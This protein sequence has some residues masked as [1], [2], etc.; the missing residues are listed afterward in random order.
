MVLGVALIVVFVLLA[1]ALLPVKKRES[2]SQLNVST[3]ALFP[4]EPV[5]PFNLRQQQ[6]SEESAAI[7]SE[8]QRRAEQLWLEELRIKATG[9]LM[10]PAPAVGQYS[11]T[12][13][14]PAESPQGRGG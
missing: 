10:N 9:L 5:R 11:E 1:L 4:A 8:Y 13:A 2:L 6:L 12:T 7:A 3:P 14:A